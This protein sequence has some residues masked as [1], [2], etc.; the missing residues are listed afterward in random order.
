MWKTRKMGDLS[1]FERRHRYC[2]YS[3]SICD[4]SCHIIRCIER[5]C[6]HTLIMGREHQ[7]RGTVGEN[8][9]WQKEI[10]VYGDGLFRKITEP[11]QHRW[12][13]KWIFT[14]K[15]LFP[16]KLPDVSFR[17]PTSTVELQLLHLRLQKVMLRCVHD[18]VTTIE[19]GHQTTG[20][21]RVIWSDVSTFT[22][23]TFGE[24]PRQ[25]TIRNVWFGSD[26]ETRGSLELL[27]WNEL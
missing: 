27:H 11:L 26:S 18:C 14:L 5:L 6:R 19:P 21:A 9:H 2:T 22:L 20:N 25:L 15:I 1:D 3:W 17:N 7:R 13:Q 23:P 10:V 4:K 12:Q 24:H 8:Q 16:Q